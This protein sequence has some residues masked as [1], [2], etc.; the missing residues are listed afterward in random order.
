MLM[1]SIFEDNFFDDMFDSF[2][3]RPV[4]SS[5][6]SGIMQTDVKDSG[7]NYELEIA[8]PGYKKEDLHAELKD[9]YLTINAEHTENKDEKDN[10]GKYIRKERYT[11]HCSRS[12]FVG[13]ELKQEDID[14]KFE[15]GVL[16]ISVP[17]EVKKPE[18]EQK[19]I[20]S[21]AG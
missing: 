5:N 12:F 11:G 13:K 17:K 14:A 8:L 18:I 20:I 3:S 16:N 21:I 1:P 9:G 19:Q 7:S 10:S 15:N 4:A 6:Y 2:F